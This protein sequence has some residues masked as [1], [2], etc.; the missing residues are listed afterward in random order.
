[1]LPWHGLEECKTDHCVGIWTKP[2]PIRNKVGRNLARVEALNMVYPIIPTQD[3][4]FPI[5]D[6]C[7]D[8]IE[9]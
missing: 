6:S 7:E 8:L 9:V 2:M 4:Y 5:P 3:K 1:M